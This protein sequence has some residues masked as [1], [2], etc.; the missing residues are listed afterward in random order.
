[1]ARLVTVHIENPDYENVYAK[2][3]YC[4]RYNTYNRISDLKETSPIGDK[5][6]KC[7][8]YDCLKEYR[9]T[10][11]LVA[12]KYRMLIYDCEFLIENKRYMYCIL[13]LAQAYEVFFHTYLLTKLIYEPCSANKFRTKNLN[14]LHDI[15]YD[16][17]K[18]LSFNDLRS[19]FIKFV[20]SKVKLDNIERATVNIRDLKCRSYKCEPRN[21]LIERETNVK[22][23]HLLLDLK[24]T[25][26]NETRNKVVHKFAYRPS[27]QEVII[28]LEEAKK[29][30][31]GLATILEIKSDDPNWTFSHYKK[32]V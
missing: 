30:L 32:P 28:S 6:V 17:A 10:G 11:D 29:I 18:E 5:N 27:L 16:S 19:I 22:L 12:M 7:E 31:Q 8:Y 13:N 25:I 9:I 4:K 23:R 3:P 2:C 24:K 15:Y 26:I 1:M 20:L 21:Y 14:M